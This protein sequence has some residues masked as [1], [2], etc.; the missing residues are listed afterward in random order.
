M[1]PKFLKFVSLERGATPNTK[2]DVIFGETGQ[3]LEKRIM[4]HE[5]DVKNYDTDLKPRLKTALIAHHAENGHNLNFYRVKILQRNLINTKKR[6]FVESL[7]IARDKNAIHFKID[8][9]GTGGYQI[10]VYL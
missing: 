3:K 7:H 10:L 8:V 1:V 6:K 9:E 2:K 4:Q 5:N